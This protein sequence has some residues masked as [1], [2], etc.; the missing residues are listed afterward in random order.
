M[1]ISQKIFTRTMLGASFLIAGANLS[2]EARAAANCDAYEAC[3][4]SCTR[5]WTNCCKNHDHTCSAY[6]NCTT[7]CKNPGNCSAPSVP[8]C[9]D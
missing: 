6:S 7:N 8:S 5:I 4:N 1:I 3:M 9:K 2:S